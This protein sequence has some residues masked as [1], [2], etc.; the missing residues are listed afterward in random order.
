MQFSVNRELPET[1][2]M[3]VLFQDVKLNATACTNLLTLHPSGKVFLCMSLTVRNSDL[4]YFVLNEISVQ[5]LIVAMPF[6]VASCC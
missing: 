2:S 6:P 3:H 4:Y 5:S 1:E